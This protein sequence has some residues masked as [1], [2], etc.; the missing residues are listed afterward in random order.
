MTANGEIKSASVALKIV[1]LA[2][3]PSAIRKRTTSVQPRACRKRA[4]GVAD[5]LAEI[6]EPSA[7]GRARRDGQRRRG[8]PQRTHAA[9]QQIPVVDLFERQ[10]HRVLVRRPGGALFAVQVVEV[11][12]EFVHDL[13]LARGGQGKR[14]EPGAER[15]CPVRHDQVS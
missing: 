1:A 6:R 12:R 7:A 4:N 15:R 8:L 2:P 11:L 13:A 3:I 5:V 10:P 14:R 9:H